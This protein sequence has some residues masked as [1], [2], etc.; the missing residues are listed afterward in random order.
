MKR[1]MN[2]KNNLLPTRAARSSFGSPSRHESL[3]QST[4]IGEDVFIGSNPASRRTFEKRPSAPTVN[5]ARTSRQP[6]RPR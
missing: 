1:S 6:S 3:N 5:V 2:T 4:S